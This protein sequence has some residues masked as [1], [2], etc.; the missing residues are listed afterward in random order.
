[1]TLKRILKSIM[2]AQE[3]SQAKLAK[4]LGIS[5]QTMWAR[6][7]AS[8]GKE[9]ATGKAVDTL[10]ALDYKLVAMPT[11]ARIP[12]GAYVVSRNAAE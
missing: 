12:D 3:I 7:D 10:A 5:T 4:R 9:L 8:S 11:D 2:L 1:M 6:L